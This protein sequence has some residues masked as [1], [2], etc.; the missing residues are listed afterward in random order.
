V[1]KN[2][3]PSM[4]NK[5]ESMSTEDPKDVEIAVGEERDEGGTVSKLYRGVSVLDK[6][7][8]PFAPR[9]GK[10]L[11]WRDTNMTLVSLNRTFYFFIISLR[12]T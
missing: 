3:P 9:E 5:S 12:L 10:A 4:T 7:T 6:H 8:D 1:K 11:V 2:E